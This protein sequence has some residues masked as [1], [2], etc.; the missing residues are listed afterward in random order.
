MLSKIIKKIYNNINNLNNNS[1]KNDI[2]LYF[3]LEINGKEIFIDTDDN[4]TF[5]NI[6]EQIK[7]K[8]V[9]A[10]LMID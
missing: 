1:G 10:I 4:G 8:Y 2:T 6:A 7:I 9:W 3:R 5:S